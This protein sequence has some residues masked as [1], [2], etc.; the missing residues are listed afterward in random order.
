LNPEIPLKITDIK[1]F[2][3]QVGNHSQFPIKAETD[4]GIYGW[5]EAGLANHERAVPGVIEYFKRF[6]IGT[7]PLDRGAHWQ[8]IYRG[9]YFE[10]NLILT[11]GISA[12]DIA[13]YDTT[14]KA[15]GVPAYQLLG[16]KQRDY[17]PAF[18]TVTAPNGPQLVEDCQM[19]VE[20]GWDAIRREFT[21]HA[22][23]H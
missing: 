21:A 20:K 9:R 17:V 12:I 19:L 14:G 7:D 8:R 22:G 23:R 5:G 13:P 16:G 4:E 2:P 18:A 6:L 3:T 1:A 11:A 10:G 15:F